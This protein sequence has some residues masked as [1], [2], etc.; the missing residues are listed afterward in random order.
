MRLFRRGSAR[1]VGSVHEVLRVS[2]RVGRLRGWLE[3]RALADL[4]AFLVKMRRYTT[5]EAKGRVAAGRRPR[6]HQAW[7]APA[8]E[9]FR[10]LVWKQGFLDGPA[11]WAFCLLSGLSQWVL[12]REH[13]RL[14]EAAAGESS[15][16]PLPRAATIRCDAANLRTHRLQLAG[17]TCERPSS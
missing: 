6:R 17:S 15:G 16:G 10:R 1:W 7:I 12:A 2:G 5:L 4:D 8:Q 9:V 14:W 13:R 3:H 11:A